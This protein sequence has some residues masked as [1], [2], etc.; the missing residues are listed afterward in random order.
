MTARDMCRVR[1]RTDQDEIVP[2][3]LPAVD[4]VPRR[5]EF[6]LGLGI[7][8]QHQ[9]GVA[10]RRRRQCL[11]G[12]LRQDMHRNPGLLGETG[13][14]VR[15]QPGIV[16][17]SGRGQHDRLRRLLLLGATG[18][19]AERGRQHGDRDRRPFLVHR[20]CPPLAPSAKIVALTTMLMPISTKPSPSASDKLPSLVSSTIAV[21]IV[22]V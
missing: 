18:A 5:D 14:D 15:E 1:A 4:A 6:L 13:Q 16:D 9:I 21:V 22:R 11:A 20:D 7:V 10:M 3:D 19:A 12:A 2:G 8:D 17:R